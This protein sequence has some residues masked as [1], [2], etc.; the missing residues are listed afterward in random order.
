[1]ILEIPLQQ[2]PSQKLEVVVNGQNLA[3]NLYIKTVN[4]IT[5]TNT[6]ITEWVKTPIDYCFIDVFVNTVA[7]VTGARCVANAYLNQFSWQQ[8]ILTG[9]LFWLD[10]SYTDPTLD[11][12]G[13]TSHLLYSDTQIMFPLP[14]VELR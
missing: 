1:M 5:A 11:T 7:L 3:I 14:L 6:D 12:L 10:E 9:Y 2:I 8:S 13:T 4:T